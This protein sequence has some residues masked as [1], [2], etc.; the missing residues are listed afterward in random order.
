MRNARRMLPVLAAATV[1]LSACGGSLDPNPPLGFGPERVF[2]DH[3]EID[4]GWRSAGLDLTRL[5]GTLYLPPGRG[6]HAVMIIHNGSNRWTRV[7]WNALFALFTSHGIGLVSY[8]K[9]GV[10]ASGGECCPY[11]EP[12]YFAH[13]AGDLIGAAQLLVDHPDIDPARIGLYGFSQG[14][15]VVPIAAAGAPERFA[16]VFIGSGPTVT[17]GEE[18][19]YS[20][21]T[22]DADCMPS[23][24]TEEEIDAALDAAGPSLFDPVPYLERMPQPSLWQYCVDDTSIPV[25]RSVGILQSL[26]AT[27]GRRFTTQLFADCNHTFVRGG[28]VCQLEGVRVDWWD[29]LFG[30]LE[31]VRFAD[32]EGP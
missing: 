7:G 13:L 5:Y 18:L 30:W 17:L 28:G 15:W 3:R 16:V 25:Q 8:D 29:P 12:F 20:E 22:G 1:V 14:G 27:Q 6:P 24:L 19:L 2:T 10:G 31:S 21:L 26:V 32:P 9:R 11:R 23:E 4:I